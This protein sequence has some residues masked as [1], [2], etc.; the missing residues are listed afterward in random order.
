MPS[1][2]FRTDIYDPNTLP[3]IDQAFAAIWY[4]LRADDPLHWRVKAPLE[5]N[6]ATS[7]AE[8]SLRIPRPT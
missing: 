7:A 8:T 2:N 3:A 5:A 1:P 4:V 6:A